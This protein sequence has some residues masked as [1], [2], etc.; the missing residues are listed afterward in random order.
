MVMENETIDKQAME[1]CETV[2]N[3]ESLIYEVLTI[4]PDE[5]K[6]NLF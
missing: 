1:L 6:H 3:L 2:Y 5:V 4:S